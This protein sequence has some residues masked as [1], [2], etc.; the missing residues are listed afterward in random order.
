MCA[1]SH[2]FTFT[3]TKDKLKH[4]NCKKQKKIR[5]TPRQHFTLCGLLFDIVMAFCHMELAQWLLHWAPQLVSYLHA[6]QGH[7][8]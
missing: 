1:Y 8:L 5:A 4:L 3:L 2:T 7:L 6:Q